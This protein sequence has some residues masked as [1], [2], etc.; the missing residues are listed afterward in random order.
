MVID[1]FMS[2]PF[3]PT[4]GQ[5]KLIRAWEELKNVYFVK[6]HLAKSDPL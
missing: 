3:L 5:I 4:L 6:V 1:M 2:S